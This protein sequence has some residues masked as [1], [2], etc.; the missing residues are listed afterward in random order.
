M[1]HDDAYDHGTYNNASTDNQQHS[2]N[3]HK[4]YNQ[5]G[6]LLPFGCLLF[7]V[8][9]VTEELLERYA[10]LPHSLSLAA[11]LACMVSA[12]PVRVRRARMVGYDSPVMVRSSVT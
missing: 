9:G 7:C 2:Y 3:T 5:C 4:H 8:M 10:E 12:P 11:M 1:S 6:R